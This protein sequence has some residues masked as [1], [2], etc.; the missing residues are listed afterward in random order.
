MWLIGRD[1][2]TDLL[3]AWLRAADVRLGKAVEPGLDVGFRDRN[4]RYVRL[5]SLMPLVGGNDVGVEQHGLV[6]RQA[7]NDQEGVFV[8]AAKEHL[9]ARNLVQFENGIGDPDGTGHG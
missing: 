4:S 6:H 7:V 8:G 9:L 1:S 5:D 2:L 3:P